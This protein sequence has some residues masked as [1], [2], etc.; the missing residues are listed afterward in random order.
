MKN[1]W[2]LQVGEAIAAEKLSRYLG[3]DFQVFFPLNS[4]LKDVDLLVVNMN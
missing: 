4:Q 2:S 3:K 1:F